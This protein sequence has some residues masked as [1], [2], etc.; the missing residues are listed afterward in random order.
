MA[1][2][3]GGRGSAD[4]GAGQPGATHSYAPSHE[5][6]VSAHGQLRTETLSVKHQTITFFGNFG[7]HNL[8]NECTLEAII[9]NVRKYLPDARLN[10][11]CPGPED[12]SERHR[13]PALLMSYRNAAAFR[14]RAA[15]LSSSP[16]IRLARRLLIRVPLEL[17]E[18]F[19]AFRALRGTH[20]LIMVGT[21]MPG[22]FGIGPLDLHYEILKWS[23]IAKMRR[24]R[25]LFV[26]V[27][28]GPID[29]PMSRWICQVRHFARGLPLI[30]RHVL[31]AVSRQHRIQYGQ[32]PRLP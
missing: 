7:T 27:G 9:Q 18:W 24:C 6:R 14:S 32:G 23:I 5:V 19:K 26:S 8:G 11:V 4:E 15:R 3:D 10:C 20:M 12:T 17:L 31:T 25:L 22:D 21:G 13:I 2:H 30:S 28:A 16:L 29:H 1:L